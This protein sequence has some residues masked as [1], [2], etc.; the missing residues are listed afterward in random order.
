[1]QNV[2]DVSD[3]MVEFCERCN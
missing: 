2:Y 1:M 3:E